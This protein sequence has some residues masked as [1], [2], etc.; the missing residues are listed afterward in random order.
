MQKKLQ[1][2]RCGKR[3]EAGYIYKKKVYCPVCF[4]KLKLEIKSK[5]PNA[6]I[7]YAVVDAITHEKNTQRK[8]S[9]WFG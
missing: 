4:E 3:M 5:N 2:A 7:V 8:L 1:C 6:T 9:E